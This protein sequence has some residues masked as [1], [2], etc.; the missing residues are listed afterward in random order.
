MKHLRRILEVAVA[1]IAV[2]YSTALRTPVVVNWLD[3]HPADAAYVSLGAGLLIAAYKAIRDQLA[4]PPA[5]PPASNGA[6]TM[7]AK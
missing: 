6:P 1:V 4:Q 5:D 3:G 7:G 2:E